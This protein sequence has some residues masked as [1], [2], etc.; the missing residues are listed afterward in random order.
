MISPSV[1]LASRM[2]PLKPQLRSVTPILNVSIRIVS[3]F[4]SYGF[5]IVMVDSALASA[6]TLNPDSFSEA[7][8]YS[9][10]F[11]LDTEMAFEWPDKAAS[12]PQLFLS[13][14][15]AIWQGPTLPPVVE[16]KAPSEDHE[17]R[18]KRD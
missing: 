11:I 4:W 16:I 9:T 17:S 7:S 1:E 15:G 14:R 5:Q 8:L 10:G 18:R 3:G 2:F 6:I 13:M 12:K